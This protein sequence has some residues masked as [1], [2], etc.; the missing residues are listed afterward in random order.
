MPV[1]RAWLEVNDTELKSG[2]I[3]NYA[4]FGGD[5]VPEGKA[6]L[7]VEFFCVGNDPI[8]R[9]SQP[10]V[11]ALAVHECADSRLIDPGTLTDTYM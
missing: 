8:T 1:P 9:L 11:V 6:C 4:A 2:R 10:K 3:T 7:C 5:M